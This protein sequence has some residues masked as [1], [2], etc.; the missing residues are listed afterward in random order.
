MDCIFCKIAAGEI[1]SKFIYEDELCLAFHDISPMAKAHALVIPKAHHD[2]L[3]RASGDA[4]LLGHLLRVCAV[5]AETLGLA[6]GYRVVTNVGENG[7]Q[8]VRHLHFH[9]L[10]GE[11]LSANL[12]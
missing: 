9:V 11:K 7:G 4:A 8:T 10:G 12:A 2:S 1:P 3:Q 5:V 6:D